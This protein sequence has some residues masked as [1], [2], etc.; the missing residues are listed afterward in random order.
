MV[1]LLNFLC[2]VFCML[3][4]FDVETL[5]FVKH[6]STHIIIWSL[7]PI[8]SVNLLQQLDLQSAGVKTIRNHAGSQAAKAITLAT[9]YP[10]SG[11]S[12][13][14]TRLTLSVVHISRAWSTA[15]PSQRQKD[16]FGAATFFL[17]G[18]L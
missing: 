8:K 18:V 3:H 14:S 12:L 17:S 16:T 4:Q 2:I 13:P 7:L 9:S 15:P 11:C 1:K 10:R 5:E 6:R